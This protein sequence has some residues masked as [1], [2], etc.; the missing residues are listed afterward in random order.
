MS[1]RL[2]TNDRGRF[3]QTVACV[4]GNNVS[5]D[6]AGFCTVEQGVADTLLQYDP[7]IFTEAQ[8]GRT[9]TIAIMSEPELNE[10]LAKRGHY[11]NSL[12][13]Q[14]IESKRALLLGLVTND[15]IATDADTNATAP[16]SRRGRPAANN[17]TE[18]TE[19]QPTAVQG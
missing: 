4:G 1:V 18:A 11:A 17:P 19:D 3:G 16:K 8:F 9:H 5:F 10:E 12:V 13:G 2:R 14:S 15:S 7:G 6:N